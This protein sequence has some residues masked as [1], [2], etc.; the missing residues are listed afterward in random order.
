M[1]PPQHLSTNLH[2]LKIHLNI[3]DESSFI[4]VTEFLPPKQ[5]QIPQDLY[6]YLVPFQ[7]IATN[8]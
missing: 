6:M 8:Y 1:D 3:L 7:A 2:P 5:F 4:N